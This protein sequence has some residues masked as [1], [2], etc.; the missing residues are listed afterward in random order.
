MRHFIGARWFR[1]NKMNQLKQELS[2]L[3]KDERWDDL[4]RFFL[5]VLSITFNVSVSSLD[6]QAIEKLLCS[7][8][9][10]NKLQDFTKFLAECASISFTLQ[11]LQK[12]DTKRMKTKAYYWLLV[13]DNTINLKEKSD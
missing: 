2:I 12:S 8:I 4:Y 9:S 7:K 3:I 11:L 6:E 1:K 13:L 5:R 10:E